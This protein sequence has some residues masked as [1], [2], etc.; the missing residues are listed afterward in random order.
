MRYLFET[1]EHERLREQIRRFAAAEIAPHAHEWEEACEFPVELYKRAADVGLTGIGYPEAL[2]GA[3]GDIGHVTAAAEEMILA[4]K[5]VGTAVGLGSHGIAIPPIVRFGT[6]EQ[7]ER[8]V[9]PVL[10]GKKIA[11]LAITEPGGGSD[12]ASL[13]TR[14]VRNGDA[15]RRSSPRACA[16][17]SSPPRCAPGLPSTAASRCSSSS[18]AH[19]AFQS[20]ASS[21]KPGGGRATPPS[22]RSRIASSRPAT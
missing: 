17:T 6:D 8:F 3:G 2:G 10:E 7:K 11:A 5:S 12:V 18:A 19:R 4:G 16:P 9:R 13:R 22:C 1:E 21:T 15:P 14:A 20:R